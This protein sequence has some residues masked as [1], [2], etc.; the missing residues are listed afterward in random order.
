MIA[1]RPSSR[2]G[3]ALDVNLS[4]EEALDGFDDVALLLLREFGEHRERERFARGAL[5]FGEVAF[6]VAEAAEALL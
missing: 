2:E 6:R 1:R 3:K 4:R 5:G